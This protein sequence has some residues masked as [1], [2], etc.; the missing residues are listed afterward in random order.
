MDEQRIPLSYDDD[1]PKLVHICEV[2]GK[3]EVIGPQEAFDTGWDYPPRMGDYG[4]VG[5]RTCGDCGIKDT[6]WWAIAVEGKR[7]S[8]E[9]TA[10]QIATLRRIAGEPESIVPK[11]E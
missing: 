2:C 8:E 6:V 9:L 3:T 7:T 1:L 4:V 11:G 5:P 10:S